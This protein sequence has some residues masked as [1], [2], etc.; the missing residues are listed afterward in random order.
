LL[1]VEQLTVE[2]PT[3]RGPARILDGVDFT[4]DQGESLGLVGE[5]GCG[6]SMTALAI[7]GLLPEATRAGGRIRFEGRDLLS[8]DEA[9]L[10]RLRGGRIAMVFQEPMTALNP[11]KSIGQ[12]VAEG[13]RLHLGLS[14]REAEDRA[15]GLL[16]RVGL[17]P[18]RFPLGLFPHQLS[19]GQRQR[20]VIA[21]ALACGPALLIA[22]EPTT[23]LDVTIQAQ[24]LDLVAQ[25]AE[26][27]GMALLMITHDLGIVAEITDR[28]MVMYAGGIVEGGPTAEL[29]GH[30]AHPYTRGLFAALP[31]SETRDEADGPERAALR[32]RLTTI[33][34]RVPDALERPAG[35]AFAPRCAHAT[36][37][38][39][40]DAPPAATIG[41][42]LGALC[43]HPILDRGK[44][45]P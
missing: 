35:C 43:F 34:G 5:S 15:A 14:R 19:G 26:D 11:V 9:T 4:L 2:I 17:P 25:V 28:V 42:G 6:K 39:H 1:E 44:G 41:H 36:E 45:A 30:M 8:A 21:I 24:I 22:D 10:C 18:A 12:Q 27:E 13:L 7:M 31:R 3:P 29:F 33:P 20:V 37:I 23:A 16:D 32:P 40:R 38:C